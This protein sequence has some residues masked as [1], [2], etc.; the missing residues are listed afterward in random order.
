MLSPAMGSECFFGEMY[1]DSFTVGRIRLAQRDTKQHSYATAFTISDSQ[2]T[3]V[4]GNN[5]IT[6][7][8]A[9]TGAALFV[10]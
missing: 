8:Q 1:S 6:Q 7:W 9:D 5:F 10:V 4:A 2:A 3:P